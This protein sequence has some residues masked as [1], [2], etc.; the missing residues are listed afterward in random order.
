MRLKA[1]FLRWTMTGLVFLGL[2]SCRT[3]NSSSTTE[4]LGAPAKIST[5]TATE[6]TTIS[7]GKNIVELGCVCEGIDAK[8]QLFRYASANQDVYKI[9]L[10][11]NAPLK[12]CIKAK[13]DANNCKLKF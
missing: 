5:V 10:A 9:S 4:S 11:S 1:E 8:W 7:Q 3:A 2:S 13:F 6:W 12:A